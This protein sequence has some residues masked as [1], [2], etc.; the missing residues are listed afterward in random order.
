MGVTSSGYYSYQKR[1]RTKL[2]NDPE[3]DELLEWV[4][5][6]SVASKFTYGSRRI[7]MA[8]NAL[9]FPVG[10]RKTRSLMREANVFVRYRKKYKVTTNSN[11]KQPVFENVLNRQFQVS[12]PNRAYV[13]DITYIRTHEGWLYLTVMIDLFSRKV[14]GW[15]MSSRMKADGVCNALLMATWQRRPERGLIVH[16]D[17]GSQYASKQYCNLLKKHGFEGSMSRKGN[18]WDNSVAESFFGR[19]KDERVDWSNYQTR[20]E[21]KQDILDYITMF[22]NNQRLHS[23]LGY[24]S[25]NQCENRYWE[26]MRKSA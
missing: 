4:K 19:L 21:A 20:E 3:H 16:S 10:R 25:P 1:K 13:S 2:N 7:R 11:H 8:L 9:G 6:I 12:E 24:Q 17:R 5:K 26:L 18:C 15:D 14:V 22:Y 23:S